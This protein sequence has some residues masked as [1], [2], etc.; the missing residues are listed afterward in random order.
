MDF[1]CPGCGADY[2]ERRGLGK[3][4]G[5]CLDCGVPVS[6]V[7][8]LWAQLD[9]LRERVRSILRRIDSG[10]DP[11]GVPKPRPTGAPFFREGPFVDD[12][13]TQE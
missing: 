2:R 5:R 6:P 1:V 4:E 13:R 3:T 12:L 7:P 10:T 8:E 9:E 11:R